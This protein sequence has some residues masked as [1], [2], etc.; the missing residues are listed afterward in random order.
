MVFNFLGYVSQEVLF[1]KEG[2][3][4]GLESSK[5]AVS[6]TWQSYLAWIGMTIGRGSNIYVVIKNDGV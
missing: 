6:V 5:Y 1:Q 3:E 2:C 4:K